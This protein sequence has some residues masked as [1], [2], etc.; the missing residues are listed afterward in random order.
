MQK[1]CLPMPLKWRD[2]VGKSGRLDIYGI[3]EHRCPGFGK[4][5]GHWKVKILHVPRKHNF[6]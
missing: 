6:T 3:F 1:N 5:V 4:K 2:F